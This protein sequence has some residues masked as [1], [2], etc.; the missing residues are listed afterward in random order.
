MRKSIAIIGGG[1][2]GLGTAYYLIKNGVPGKDIT[3]FESNSYLGGLASGIKTAEWEWPVDKV[4]HH[5]FT[6]D[7]WAMSIAKELGL[8]NKVIIKDTKSSSYYDGKIAELDSAMSLLKLPFLSLMGRIRMGAILALLRL[9]KNFLRYEKET[10]YNFIKRTMGE[11]VFRI[12]WEPLFKGKFGSYADKISAAWFWA[13]INPRTKSLAYFKGGFQKYA[14]E[15][16]DFLKKKEV[17]IELNAK[18]KNVSGKTNKFSIKIGSDNKDFDC[19]VFATP[20]EVAANLFKDFSPTYKDKLKSYDML[21]AQ[22]FVLELKKPFFKDKTYW[23]NVQDSSF[24]FM[25][26][27][28]HTN[29]VSPKHYNNKHIIWVGKYLNADN[30]LWSMDEKEL[31]AKVINYLKKINSSFS[32]KD[33]ERSFLTRFR[34][35]QPV[36][37]I[38]YSKKIPSVRAPVKGIYLA[39]LNH[40]YPW[41]RGTNNAL[42][43]GENVAKKIICDL[44]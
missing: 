34:Y 20:L 16:G 40:I 1:Y 17:K 7:R 13:R 24:P 26:V 23:L 10:S 35:A 33:I 6:T 42:G 4:I 29:F 38:N 43:L 21:G 18:I 14:D 31:L 15:L 3:I 28:E 36:I 39:S 41:D 27:A 22:Y 44:F 8:W 19:V 5:W 11:K 12:M 37:P 9:D 25:M 30:P 32:E 2:S